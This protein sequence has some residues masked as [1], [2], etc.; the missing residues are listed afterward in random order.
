MRIA[1]KLRYDHVYLRADFLSTETQ[2]GITIPLAAGR[3]SSDLSLQTD[4]LL[5]TETTCGQG[6]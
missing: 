4:G 3:G 2:R 5:L 1:V 6:R